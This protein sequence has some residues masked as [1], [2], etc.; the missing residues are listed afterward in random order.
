MGFKGCADWELIS[1][2]VRCIPV[3]VIGSGDVTAAGGAVSML[4]RTGCIA[5]MIGRAARGNPWLL[6]AGHHAVEGLPPPPVARPSDVYG[7]AREHLELHRA[8]HGDSR[9][10]DMAAQLC[11]YVKG[12]PGASKWRARLFAASSHTELTAVLSE[13]QAAA[14]GCS[15]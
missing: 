14:E 13:L 8:A 15:L 3:P 12:F 6:R 2:L 5:V 11:W 9:M 4:E 7:V 1:L 10:K